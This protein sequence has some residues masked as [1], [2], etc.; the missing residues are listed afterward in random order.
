VLEAELVGS[1]GRTR[2]ADAMSLSTIDAELAAADGFLSEV[3][4]AVTLGKVKKATRDGWYIYDE[5][6]CLARLM[7]GMRYRRNLVAKLT[8]DAQIEAAA[9]TLARAEKLREDSQRLTERLKPVRKL[10]AK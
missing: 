3:L 1:G 9:Q 4:T 5:L 10:R 7:A 2:K 6:W 8:G